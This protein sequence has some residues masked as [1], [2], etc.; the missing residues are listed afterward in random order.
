MKNKILI[1]ALII[2]AAGGLSGILYWQFV[3]PQQKSNI[4]ETV[5]EQS[6]VY[7]NTQYGFT[8]TLP[9]SWKGYTIVTE[10]WEGWPIDGSPDKRVYGPKILIRH[11]LWTTD[12]PRQDIP[13]MVFTYAEWNLIRQEKLSLGAAPIGPTELGRN[14]KYVFAL[15]ARY[16]YAFP[17]GF[18]EVEKILL[19]KPLSALQESGDVIGNSGVRGMVKIGPTCPVQRIPPD[20]QCADRPYAAD[21]EITNMAGKLVKKVSSG[22]DGIFETNLPPGD[23]IISQA[24]PRPVMPRSSPVQFT[25]SPGVFVEIL[26]Q[27]DSGI[28]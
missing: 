5:P 8:F 14:A 18:E 1:I 9:I 19:G 6:I 28:R 26:I 17:T 7:K 15:P 22:I 3:V 16:N 23:Y 12:N 25:V 4:P 24:E 2:V 27:F 10:S 11:P 21:F 20:P 13:I